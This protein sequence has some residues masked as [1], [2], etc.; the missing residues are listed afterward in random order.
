MISAENQQAVYPEATFVNL[1]IDEN[2]FHAASSV[3]SAVLASCGPETL[4][5]LKCRLDIMQRVSK[6]SVADV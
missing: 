3:I 1:D 5:N 4:R 2:Q 6:V